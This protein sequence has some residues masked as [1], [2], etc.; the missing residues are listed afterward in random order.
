MQML[1]WIKEI[2]STSIWDTVAEVIESLLNFMF[3]YISQVVIDPTEPGKYLTNFD[4]YLRGVEFFAGGLLVI[5]VV[6]AVFRQL[7]GVMYQSEKS[8]GTY[9][10]HITFAGALIYILPK[11]VTLV[12][13]PINNALINFIGE[14]GI[15]TSRIE[16]SFQSA[17]GLIK[18][19]NILKL[20]FLILIIALFALG[21]AAAIRYIETLLVILISPVVALSVI[22]NSDG[23]NIWIRETVAIIFTQTIHFLILQILISIM[24]GVD[25]F[26]VMMILSI[27]TIAVGLKGPQILRQY[28]Y[29]TGTS[30]VLVSSAGT[31]GRIGMIGML[32]KR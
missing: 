26:M 23:L 20:I 6:L 28:L 12:F 25:N 16:D 7:S 24:A 10:L 31:A 27:G 11:T 22:N 8:V 1:D 32:V 14:V 15:D 18:E 17:W 3:K 5:F 30:S 13:L 29:K 2:I 9:F 4:D 19:E 21:I